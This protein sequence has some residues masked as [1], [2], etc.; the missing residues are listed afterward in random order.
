MDVKMVIRRVLVTGGCGFIGVNFVR[1]LLQTDPAIELTNLDSLTYAGNPHNVAGSEARTHATWLA[2]ARRPALPRDDPVS[3]QQPVCR[4]QG[5][6]RL[7]V[8]AAHHTFG[9]THHHPLFQQLR[10]LRVPREADPS[11]HHQRPGRPLRA[12]LRRR[13]AGARLN[14]RDGPCRGIEAALRLGRTGE[15]YNLGGKSER[16]NIDVTRTILEL[17]GKPES[18]IRH[19]TDRLGH[20]RRY[21]IDCTKAELSWRPTVTFEEGLTSTVAWYKTNTAWGYRARSRA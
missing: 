4:Q 12:G 13:Q 11:V 19:V 7:L 16:P 20:D 21:A 2:R 17:C 3:T 8:R 9:L 18:L 1:H 10:A 5:G 15:V 14:P 6:G